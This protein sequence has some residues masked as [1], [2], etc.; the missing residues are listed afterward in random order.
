M[1][2]YST[3]LLSPMLLAEVKDAIK[4][5]TD[6]GSVEIYVQGGVVSQ[7]STRKIKKTI[8]KIKS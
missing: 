8:E 1:K 3:Q 2:N 5:V 7:I 4:S 6:Y